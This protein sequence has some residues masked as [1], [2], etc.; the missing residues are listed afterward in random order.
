MTPDLQREFQTLRETALQQL[1]DVP[2]GGSFRHVFSLWVMPT[3]TPAHRCTLYAPLPLV[4]GRQPFAS[5]TFWRSDL[6]LEKLRTPVERLRHP[7]D[8]SPTI[9]EDTLWLTDADVEDLQQRIRGISVPLYLGPATVAG[10]DGTSF[11]FRCDEIFYEASLHWWE[12]QPSE[13]RPFTAVIVQIASELESRRKGKVNHG[14]PANGPS[15]VRSMDGNFLEPRE[16]PVGGQ[17]AVA[18]LSF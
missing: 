16:S 4:K 14:A 5:F 12:D 3:F 13:W 10:C 1:R 11:E 9:E 8:L 7:K 18:E 15:T 17:K 2:E 6:D